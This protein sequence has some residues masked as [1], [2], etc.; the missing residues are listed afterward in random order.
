MATSQLSSKIALL[1]PLELHPT[2]RW[3]RRTLHLLRQP[4]WEKMR[5]W[6]MRLKMTCKIRMAMPLAK[7]MSVTLRRRRQSRM[8]PEN[9]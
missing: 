7:R 9:I 6:E 8:L 4:K 2:I 1:R 3:M 5:R